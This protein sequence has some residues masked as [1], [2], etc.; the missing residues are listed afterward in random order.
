MKVKIGS[1][2]EDASQREIDI[3][4]DDYDTWNMDHTL[5][6]LIL[7]MLKQLKGVKHGAPLVENS[8]VPDSLS[9]PSDQ[10][11]WDTD[12]NFFKRWDYVLDEMIWAFEQIVDED[13]E[14]PFFEKTGVWKTKE[15]ENGGVEVIST[16]L[17]I[18]S[19]GLK[20]HRRRVKNGTRLFGKYYQDLWD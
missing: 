8:D 9:A 11:S 1:Y 18:D 17:S 4:I 6:L 7:P 3:H 14:S 16:G 20:N 19:E 5:G 10:A 13:D 12:E 15:L 2:P